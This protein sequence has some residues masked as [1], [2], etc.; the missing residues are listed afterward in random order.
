[1]EI[2]VRYES[3]SRRRRRRRTKIIRMIGLVLAVV[4]VALLTICVGAAL[5][6]AR[7][8]AVGAV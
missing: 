7:L 1:M 4:G 6:L 3:A 5:G 2:G 8:A